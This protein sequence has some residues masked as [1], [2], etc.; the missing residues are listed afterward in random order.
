M[1]GDYKIEKK[2]YYLFR[3]LHRVSKFRASGTTNDDGC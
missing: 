3:V 2:N 1:F